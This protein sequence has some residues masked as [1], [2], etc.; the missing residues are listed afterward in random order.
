MFVRLALVFFVKSVRHIYPIYIYPVFPIWKPLTFVCPLLR[1]LYSYLTNGSSWT[2]HVR[3]QPVFQCQLSLLV[4][5]SLSFILYELLTNYFWLLSF[6][7]WGQSISKLKFWPYEGRINIPIYNEQYRRTFRIYLNIIFQI[8][9]SS[10]NHKFDFEKKKI[11]EKRDMGKIIIIIM[12]LLFLWSHYK[13]DL[14]WMELIWLIGQRTFSWIFQGFENF[15]SYA[16]VQ[17]GRPDSKYDI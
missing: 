11:F 4:S 14:N 8:Y 12:R 6:I 15:C 5:I 16:H 3:V 9:I 1:K 2:V 17:V 10:T 7:K 13:H